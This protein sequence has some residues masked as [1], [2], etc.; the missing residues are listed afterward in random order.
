MTI[1]VNITDTTIPSGIASI[2]KDLP[3]TKD[4][5]ADN[6]EIILSFGDAYIYHTG[7]IF[8]ATWRKTLPSHVKVVIDDTRCQEEA[9]RVITK[10]GFRELIENNTE[11]PSNVNYYPGKVP[12]QPVVRGYSTELAI[13]NICKI[14]ETSV[15]QLDMKA[16]RTL[17]SELCENVYA[18]SKF[19]TPG[20]ISASLHADKCEIAI[21]D[22]GIGILNSYLEG[23][24]DEAKTRISHGASAIAL[25]IDG[26]VSSKPARLLGSLNTHYGYGLRIVRGLVEK[27]RG[28]LTI[29]SG[30]EIVTVERYQKNRGNLEK[31][32]NGTF[33]GLMIDLQNPLSLEEVFDEID[34]ET[35][36]PQQTK[37]SK[38][39]ATEQP[40]QEME[41]V[42]ANYGNQLLTRELGI[43]IRADLAT[44][45]SSGARVK[46]VLDGIDDITPSV[47]DECFGKLAESMGS[48]KFNQMVILAGGQSL[49]QRL[50]NLVIKN[51][52]SAK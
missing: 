49:V 1:T 40:L 52:I 41:F 25:A 48:D 16:F 35:F 37:K 28:R 34:K 30:K 36:S 22:S 4:L 5:T 7:L 10:S 44:I 12:L 38:P 29:A 43:A 42:V 46:V 33:V 19:E 3:D 24:N 14:F 23:S 18:H 13:N 8:L 17:L 31:S 45:L 21:V 51:R 2:I 15:G 20:Y 26:W 9:R 27:N 11:A 39:V 50:I 6:V 32:W 47:A